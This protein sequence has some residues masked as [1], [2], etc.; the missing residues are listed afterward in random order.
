MEHMLPLFVCAAASDRELLFTLPQAWHRAAQE[1]VA[2]RR[3]RGWR[4]LRGL[5]VAEFSA[6]LHA[7][8]RAWPALTEY[9]Q[10]RQTLAAA[11][12][13]NLPCWRGLPPEL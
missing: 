7:L 11:T 6:P 13:A 2:A 8:Q 5:R 12:A 3:K 1:Q 4:S 10:C 9:Q